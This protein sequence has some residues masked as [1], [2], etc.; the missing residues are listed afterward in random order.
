MPWRTRPSLNLQPP[1]PPTFNAATAVMPWRTGTIRTPQPLC[2][3]LQ[4]GHGGDA[5]ENEIQVHH[6]GDGQVLNAPT[7]VRP[8]RTIGSPSTSI[9]WPKLQCGHGDDAVE[10]VAPRQRP[11]ESECR[12]NAATA[13]MPWRT[14]EP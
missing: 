1:L 13:V 2:R 9:I 5:V 10:N 11:A 7:A 6:L 14:R 12:F 8:W 4:C 3:F